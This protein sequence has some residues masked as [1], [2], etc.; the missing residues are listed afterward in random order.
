MSALLILCS[1]GSQADSREVQI[2]KPLELGQPWPLQCALVPVR[3]SPSPDQFKD[4]PVVVGSLVSWIDAP[5]SGF[6]EIDMR[7]C[8]VPCV[9]LKVPRN[10]PRQC[11]EQVPLILGPMARTNTYTKIHT[12]THTHTHTN[13]HTH[14]HAIPTHTSNAA[15][16]THTHTHTH[17]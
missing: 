16:H 8:E 12:R 14:T 17:T 11:V 7:E 1:S 13:T 10:P 9:I 2:R 3:G 5:G 15:G 4:R 6:D